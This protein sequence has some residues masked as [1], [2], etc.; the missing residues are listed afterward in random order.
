M[1]GGD[2]YFYNE[3]ADHIDWLK[4]LPFYYVNG[5]YLFVHAGVTPGVYKQ[6]VT[7]D[8]VKRK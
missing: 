3:A 6:I 7:I 1:N 2:Y 4:S 5:D 8:V